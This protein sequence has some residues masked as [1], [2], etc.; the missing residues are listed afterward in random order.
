MEQYNHEALYKATREQLCEIMDD[1]L[2]RVK[3]YD[4]EMYDD[5]ESDLYEKVNGQHF[6]KSRYERALATSHAPKWTIEQVSDY[7]RRNG[8]RFDRYNEYDLAYEMNKLYDEY[9]STLGENADTYYRM[10]RQLMDNRDEPEGRAWRD[11]RSS[12]YNR[13]R[14]SRGRYAAE[15]PDRGVRR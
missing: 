6:D 9:G 3:R 2:H 15:Y 5:L 4:P 14:D 11:Y 8:D 13:R 12:S 10:S 7:A 1:W